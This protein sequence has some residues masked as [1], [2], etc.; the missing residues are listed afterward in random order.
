MTVHQLFSRSLATVT[1]SI[2]QR[3]A[4][5]PAIHLPFDIW[6]KR[7][8]RIDF[9]PTVPTKT[10]L[11]G[12]RFWVGSICRISR[13]ICSCICHRFNRI[14]F[15]T[16]R[17]CLTGLGKDEV[18]A[19]IKVNKTLWN[20]VNVKAFDDFLA[21]KVSLCYQHRESEFFLLSLWLDGLKNCG[22]TFWLFISTE[23]YLRRV[24][25]LT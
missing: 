25:L 10:K 1:L 8:R 14:F 22:K 3:H 23:S 24:C 18:H 17:W 21:P 2:S 13:P 4:N 7:P 12:N 19:V 5:L 15:M 20:R 16:A 6:A 11:L 9:N